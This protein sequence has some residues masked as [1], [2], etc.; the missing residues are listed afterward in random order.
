ME[1]T[2]ELDRIEHLYLTALSTELMDEL[3]AVIKKF[4]NKVI[5]KR[6][7]ETVNSLNPHLH[8]EL[9]TYRP[10]TYALIIKLINLDN[11]SIELVYIDI[12]RSKRL[13]GE[14]VLRI[15]NESYQSLLVAHNEFQNT[16]NG[17][18]DGI[19]RLRNLRNESTSLRC[20]LSEYTHL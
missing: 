17:I 11:Y 14:D 6:F 4:D 12:N 20:K 18:L 19:E 7:I 16:R 1:R 15:L 8:T 13:P 5:N 10:N 2:I 9:S 3:R